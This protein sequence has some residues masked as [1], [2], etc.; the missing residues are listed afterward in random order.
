M[1]IITGVRHYDVREFSDLRDMLQ[2]SAERYG[3]QVAFRFR[4]TP[5]SEPESRTYRQF[6]LD[7]KA[8]GSWL[9]TLPS[10]SHRIGIIGENSYTWCLAHAAVINGAGT[11]VPID[12][13]LPAAE[14]IDLLGRADVDIL[15]YDPF[16]QPHLD[17][18][19][20]SHPKLKSLICMHPDQL[21]Q[22]E[23]VRWESTQPSKTDLIAA[24][25]RY[26]RLSDGL[27]CGRRL[28]ESGHRTWLDAV[29]DPDVMATLLFTSGTTSASKA[30]MLSHR[31]LSANIRALAGVVTLPAGIR[32]LSVLPLHHTFENTCGLYM[33]LYVGAQIHEADGL[34]YIQKNLVEYQIEMIIGV[35][36]LFNNFY[37]RVQSA[38]EKTGK[39]KLV[40]RLIPITQI[41]R[42]VGIDLRRRIYH[43]LLDAF[44][45]HLRLGICGAAPID[46]DVISFF[47]AIGI[48]ILEGYGMTEASPVISGCNTIVFV[49]GTVGQPLAGITVAIDTD[50]DGGTGEIL[51]RSDCVMLGYY[52]DPE[53][54]AEAIDA[55]GWLHTGDM[56]QIDPKTGCLQITGRLKSMIVLKTGKKV[57]PE[58]I[59]HLI[60]QHEIIRESMVWGELDDS[61]DVVVSAKFV[62]D[63]DKLEKEKG[64][65]VDDQSIRQMLDQL[66]QDI[67]AKMPSFRSIRHYVYSFQ[68]MVKTTTLKIKRPIEIERM[69]QLMQRQQ[70]KWRELTGRNIDTLDDPSRTDEKTDESG[71]QAD[72]SDRDR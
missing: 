51:T 64:R 42:K 16:F 2:Q 48:R 40:N 27:D 30:V 70:L 55:E 9:T 11:V 53:A 69:K 65:Q 47:D 18:A 17:Q 44:G 67:N 37:S 59:E 36:V 60:G 66:I 38:L 61:G 71:G 5:Q 4:E 3:D 20:Q 63:R 35:P 6:D 23:T 13:L 19:V 22:P 34:R 39:K 1:Q 8:L 12:R 46:P 21:N 52:H 28:I 45:G 58:E 14:V 41:L 7:V 56:G 29:I 26:Y 49:P 32:M 62:I 54:T 50:E 15:F 25:V 68:D 33:A 72:E 43:Q 31:N 57:F 24:T 10:E